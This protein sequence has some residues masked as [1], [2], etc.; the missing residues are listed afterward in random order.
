MLQHGMQKEGLI[1]PIDGFDYLIYAEDVLSQM[2]EKL[3]GD[4]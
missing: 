3:P 2:R 1:P 4:D